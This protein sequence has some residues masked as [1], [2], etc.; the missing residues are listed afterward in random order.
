MSKKLNHLQAVMSEQITLRAEANRLAA[1]LKWWDIFLKTGKYRRL[2]RT[3]EKLIHT[4]HQVEYIL[5]LAFDHIPGL[6]KAFSELI[7]PY[8]V[9]SVQQ[10]QALANRPSA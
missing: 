7:A 4:E 6:G 1:S 3:E 9:M 10:E 5:K 2:V 8:G